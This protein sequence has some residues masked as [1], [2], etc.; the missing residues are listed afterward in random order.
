[1]PT[2]DADGPENSTKSAALA[3][4]GALVKRNLF[5]GFNLPN[6]VDVAFKQLRP[7]VSLATIGKKPISP[8]G[9]SANAAIFLK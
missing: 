9:H 7:G 6:S 1:M 8:A 4:D 5:T 2:S 3:T